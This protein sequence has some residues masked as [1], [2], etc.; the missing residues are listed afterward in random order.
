ME[1]RNKTKKKTRAAVEK[2][3]S[4][5]RGYRSAS[6]ID[7]LIFIAGLIIAML[8]VR[9]FMLEPVR[10]DGP[11]M[12]NTLQNDERCVVEKV[13][14]WFT[15]PKTGDIVI[16]RFPGRGSEN[17]VKRVIATEGQTIELGEE[18]VTDPET[19]ISRV[20]Y[21]VLIDGERLDESQWADT[22]LFDEG[23]KNIPLTCEGSQNGRYT[24]P[25]G[26]VFVMGDH[27]T[28]SQDSRFVGAIPLH[29]VVGR[30]H[31]V[32]Y[33]FSDMRKVD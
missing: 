3:H 25:K 8:A 15:R 5:D 10:V 2:L 28:N 19:N 23:W 11:S 14:Y 21:Y 9:A 29:D 1:N 31:G 33:P 6:N 32:L 4:G 20:Q 27:R 24:V 22:M 16:I 18:T 13:S 12:M 7:F 26:C 17:F 30:L